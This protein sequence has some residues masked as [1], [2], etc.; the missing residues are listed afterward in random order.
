MD[1][2]LIESDDDD[3]D[4][5]PSKMTLVE[6]RES[7]KGVANFIPQDSCL[8]DEDPLQAQRLANDLLAMQAMCVMNRKQEGI[9][10]FFFFFS[11]WMF[12]WSCLAECKYFTCNV[13][14]QRCVYSCA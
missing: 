5:E 3:V 4:M 7:L 12:F 8:G 1:V 11:W 9:K 10:K 6:C 14:K 13:G 2:E